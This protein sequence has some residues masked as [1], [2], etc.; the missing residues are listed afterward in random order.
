MAN[1]PFMTP[2]TSELS[3]KNI[4]K[5]STVMV[6]IEEGSPISLIQII[7]RVM[8]LEEAPYWWME[9][10]WH[11]VAICSCRKE[12]RS[13]WRLTY[14]LQSWLLQTKG[15][16]W[17]FEQDSTTTAKSFIFL[18]PFARTKVVSVGIQWT[19]LFG[20]DLLIVKKI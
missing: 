16:G 20:T 2:F 14:L 18:L 13:R 19:V 7:L 4:K 6:G 5:M 11:T 1:L 10:R 8:A 3:H 17:L 15:R 12:M 9:F